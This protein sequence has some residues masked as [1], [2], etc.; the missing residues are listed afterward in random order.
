MIGVNS[1]ELLSHVLE[2]L[3]GILVSVVQCPPL[4]SVRELYD[5]A[6]TSLTDHYQLRHSIGQKLVYVIYLWVGRWV[7]DESQVGG[8]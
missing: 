3:Y 5:M 2:L 1:L 4:E 8:G 6:V 7:M